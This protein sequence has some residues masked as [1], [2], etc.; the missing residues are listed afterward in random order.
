[1]ATDLIYE[2]LK[3]DIIRSYVSGDLD[4]SVD[5][6]NMSLSALDRLYD[7]TKFLDLRYIKT[8]KVRLLTK[9]QEAVNQQVFMS[10]HKG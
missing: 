2:T 1:M 5:Q 3:K 9:I 4:N 6:I 8:E 7:A 10:M